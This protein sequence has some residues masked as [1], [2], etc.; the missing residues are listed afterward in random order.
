LF[1]KV[2]QLPRGLCKL[3]VKRGYSRD[4][5]FRG[6]R[7]FLG[8]TLVLLI[9]GCVSGFKGLVHLAITP[10]N[11]R[12]DHSGI[13]I[14]SSI[15]SSSYLI[16]PIRGGAIIGGIYDIGLKKGFRGVYYRPFIECPLQEDSMM[17]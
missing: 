5:S 13:S 17:G 7:G 15:S 6:I 10:E 3:K 14:S 8:Y 4:M 1:F 9:L 12:E 16:Y 11:V 2:A